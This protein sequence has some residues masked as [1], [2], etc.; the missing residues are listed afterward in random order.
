MRQ[1]NSKNV[2]CFFLF[3]CAF[4]L[5][6]ASGLCADDMPRD[7]LCAVYITGI[8]C[9]NC[10]VTDP[11]LFIDSTAAYPNLIIFEY[12]IYRYRKENQQ[13]KDQYF[14]HYAPASGKIFVN[15]RAIK[16]YLYFHAASVLPLKQ[17]HPHGHPRAW[18]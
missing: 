1:V 6:N 14:D 15:S 17:C 10:A 3:L 18:Q 4:S 13:V 12:E 11:S 7:P 8:G 2:F 5:M 9:G 16:K